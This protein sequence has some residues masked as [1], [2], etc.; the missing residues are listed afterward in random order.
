VLILMSE[1]EL[2]IGQFYNVRIDS[3]DDFDLYGSVV[4]A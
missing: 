2:Q 3:A 4:S 1:G